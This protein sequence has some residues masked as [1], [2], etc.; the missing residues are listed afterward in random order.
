MLV[1]ESTGISDVGRKR[2]GNEMKQ[3]YYWTILGVG[4]CWIGTSISFLGGIANELS[5]FASLIM[6]II[7]CFISCIKIKS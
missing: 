7:L 1:I 5:F 6:G 3:E 2:K 4:A